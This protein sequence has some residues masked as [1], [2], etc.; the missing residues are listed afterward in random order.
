MTTLAT[1]TETAVLAG[2]FLGQI[3]V[4]G[5]AAAAGTYL[6]LG[7]RGAKRVSLTRDK[8]A[9]MGVLFGA[10]ATAAGGTMQQAVHGI[11]SVPTN[12]FQGVGEQ[13]SGGDFG[14]AATALVLGIVTYMPDWK[15]LSVPAL[16]GIGLGASAAQVGGVGLIASNAII[17]A[18]NAVGLA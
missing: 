13:M 16:G 7:L 17:M 15:K 4:P 14:L 12:V 5:F 6:F 3:G 11:G 10:L 18:A 2:P 1:A 8:A 9:N